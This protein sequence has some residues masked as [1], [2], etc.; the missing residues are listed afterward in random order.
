MLERNLSIRFANGGFQHPGNNTTLKVFWNCTPITYLFF[1]LRIYS[2]KCQYRNTEQLVRKDLRRC[3]AQTQAQSRVSAEDKGGGAASY[4]VRFWKPLRVKTAELLWAT[5]SKDRTVNTATYSLW[6]PDLSQLSLK[7]WQQVTQSETTW[8]KW[9]WCPVS[10]KY[11][12]SRK[13][14]LNARRKHVISTVFGKSQP[15]LM[16]SVQI[17]S[18]LGLVQTTYF[19]KKLS[20]LL[21][22]EKQTKLDENCLWKSW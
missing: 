7:T 6:L 3:L 13:G 4:P 12:H 16:K 21:S 9:N 19:N 18:G 17:Y 5:C 1:N 15:V 14:A 11:G 22:F 10:Q 2:N 8:T 20:C